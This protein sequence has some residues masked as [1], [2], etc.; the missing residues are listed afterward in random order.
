MGK[1]IINYF[2]GIGVEPTSKDIEFF[3][4]LFGSELEDIALEIKWI[5][6]H[7]CDKKNDPKGAECLE[8][9]AQLER[10]AESYR[11]YKCN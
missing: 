1:Y 5:N 3:Y 10:K 11:N 7:E 2:R 4:R 9:T 6:E 8:L